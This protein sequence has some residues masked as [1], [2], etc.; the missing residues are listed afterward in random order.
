VTGAESVANLVLPLLV[1]L[2]LIAA[3][4]SMAFWRAL[5]MQQVLATATL[6]TST[7]LTA[8]LLSVTARDGAQA[9]TIGGWPSAIGITLIA[10][11]FASLLLLVSLVVVFVVL[12][13]AIGQPREDKAAYY[14]HPLY[15]V[16]TAGVTLC[17][18]TGDL[19]NLFVA[20]EIMLSA[21]YALITIG[22]R[23]AQVRSGMSYVVINLLASTLLVTAIALIYAATGSLDL[24]D[25]A[26]R[27]TAIDPTVADALGVLLLV[28]LGV[29]AAIFP[30]FFWLP[31]A[32]PTAPVTVTAV[33][34]G[35]LT[36]VGV[37]AIIRTQTLL[38]PFDGP[39]VLLLWIAGL[40]MLTGVLGAIV[41]DDIK[42]ILSFHIVSQVGYMLFGLALGSPIGLAA[43]TLYMVHHIPVKTALF[44]VGGLVEAGTGTGAL[45]RLGGLLRSAPLTAGLFLLVALSLAGIPPLSG[46][47]GK[48]SLVQAGVASEAWTI[49]LLSLAVSVLTLFSMTKIWGRVFWGQPQTGADAAPFDPP[50]AVPRLMTAG[51]ATLVAVTLVIAAAAG[52]IWGLAVQAGDGLADPSGYATAVLGGD[53]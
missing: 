13:Y 8:Y 27:L 41:Q 32:Y 3:A 37:Y 29:K 34:A 42:R 48:L 4:V 53:R 40:T 28:A 15:L 25:V 10:D 2:P 38:F 16:L 47:L 30:L 19:F 9:V 26:D 7:G 51:A 5:R 35:L 50:R 52:P 14:F 12:L 6:A 22:G 23:A 46:F 31:D 39:D 1:V 21:S 33:F 43:A 24:A 17:F 36:K 18:L 11:V 45:H 49:T 20:I 44:L